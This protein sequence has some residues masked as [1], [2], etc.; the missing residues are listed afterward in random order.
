MDERFYKIAVPGHTK[1]SS[2]RKTHDVAVL[3]P[4]E[5]LHKEFVA[6]PDLPARAG[7]AVRPEEYAQHPIARASPTPVTP[8]GFYMDGC[9]FTKAGAQVLVF[10]VVNI[11]SG[12][13]HLAAVLRK[14]E[15]CKCGCRGWCSIRPLLEFFRWSFGALG[16]GAYPAADRKSTRLNSSHSQQSR[17]PSSA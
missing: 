3:P 11:L 5:L 16:M 10:V 14:K 12:A 1:H 7:T 6:Q 4:H 17:M 2:G 15:M 8:L 13:Q 9:Q